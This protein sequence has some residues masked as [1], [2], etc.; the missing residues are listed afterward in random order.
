MSAYDPLQTLAECVTC[1][2]MRT[3]ARTMFLCFAFLASCKQPAENPE[4]AYRHCMLGQA[5]D[6]AKLGEITYEQAMQFGRKCEGLAV[7][8]AAIRSQ[9]ELG[10][11][12]DPNA[13]ATVSHIRDNLEMIV[14]AHVCAVASKRDPKHCLPVM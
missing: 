5:R 14:R 13:P 1:R 10:A 8:A 9:N 3:S 11:K 6:A 7:Q 4:V 12:F 2:M